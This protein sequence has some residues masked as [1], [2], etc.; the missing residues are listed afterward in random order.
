MILYHGSNVA[1]DKVGAQIRNFKSGSISLDELMRRIKYL[2]GITFQY[3]FGTET[4][5]KTLHKL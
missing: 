4:A 3:Y 2:K 5:I 1:I